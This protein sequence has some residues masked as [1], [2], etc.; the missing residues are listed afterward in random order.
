[1]A[2]L[3]LLF[4]LGL[5][6]AARA[7]TTRQ[8]PRVEH[9][10][11]ILPGINCGACGYAG[12][13]GYAEAVV[14]GEKVNLCLPGGPEVAEALADLMG[15]ELGDTVR[16]RAVVHCQGGRSRCGDRFEYV[17]EQDCHAA[18]IT[19]GGP[20]ACLFGCLGMGSCARACPFDAIAM[21]EERLPVI[22]AEKCTACGVCVETC[23][24][25]LIS[26][27]PVHD[28][29]YLGCSSHY[30]GKTVKEI[31]SVGCIACG[32]C[33]KRDPH[34]AIVLEDNLPVLDYEKADGDFTTAAE[35]CPMD[36]FVI[37]GEPVPVE[38]GA[39][40]TAASSSE[41]AEG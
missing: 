21:S 4:G 32:L 36:C 6:L 29:I 2:V 35:V 16:L 27:L 39:G 19:S 28:R 22:D 20:K 11:D 40:E 8:D 17:G 5:V 18:H 1:M 24:R 12:C 26:L 3:G 14:D 33:A 34:D 31:C 10:L 25:D 30:R 13:R 41:A 15:V 23:P 37:Q 38:A 9:V 7:F